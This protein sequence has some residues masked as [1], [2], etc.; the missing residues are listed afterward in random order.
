[1]RKLRARLSDARRR[2]EAAA[3]QISAARRTKGK[4]DHDAKSMLAKNVARQA[5]AREARVVT[6]VR[7]QL[8]RTAERAASFRFEK[9][10]G[11]S[12]FVDYAPAPLSPI[13]CVQ[14]PELRAGDRVLL[15]DVRLAI[16]RAGR[17]RISGPNGCGKSTLL[18]ALRRG[19]RVPGD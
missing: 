5:E 6:V 8:E 10:L 2:R 15:R 7:R 16:P 13:L 12:L 19:A 18:A 1:E 17:V 14:E 3:S 4:R 11:R 9:E